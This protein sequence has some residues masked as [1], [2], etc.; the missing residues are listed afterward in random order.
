MLMK[1][2]LSN[3]LGKEHTIFHLHSNHYLKNTP[4]GTSP[5]IHN[6]RLLLPVLKGKNSNKFGLHS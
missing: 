5:N 2:K 6:Y 3:L 1:C 4:V